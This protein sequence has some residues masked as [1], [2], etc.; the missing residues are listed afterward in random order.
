MTTLSIVVPCYNESAGVDQLRAKMLPVLDRLADRY[1]IELILV[2]DGSSDDTFERLT[3]LFGDRP[4]TRIVRHPK[5]LNLGG[6]LRTGI[7][8]AKGD[9]VANLDSDCTY[10]PDLLEPM[11]EE[12]E[13]GADFVTVSP[14]HP[15]GTVDG[16][17]PHRL[18]LSKS[19]SAA[20]RL[21][22]GKRFYT[23]TALNRV[24]RRALC[25]TISSPEFDFT[26]LAEMML[27][28][29]KQNYRVAEVP[30]ILRVRQFGESKMKLKRTIKAHLR[31]LGRL[32][33][34][35]RSFLA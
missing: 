15:R 29:L 19:L 35:P 24:Y 32:V 5:N 18:F 20:Y 31:L 9:L 1:Q 3:A 22:L 12:I 26:A 30:A 23:Y 10:D 2:D 21:I 6:A 33:F 28:A 34:M 27:K 4:H 7:R 8:E 17:P 14:Y 11:L 13:R 16:V 25:E